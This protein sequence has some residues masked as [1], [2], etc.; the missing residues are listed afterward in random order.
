MIVQSYE[1]FCLQPTGKASFPFLDSYRADKGC[2]SLSDRFP[3]GWASDG[4]RMPIRFL[5]DGHRFL[6]EAV[7]SQWES[8]SVFLRRWTSA[9]ISIGGNIGKGRGR[10]RNI[11]IRVLSWSVSFDR[12]CLS[13]QINDAY[14]NQ[15]T[16]PIQT[17]QQCPS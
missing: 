17:S 3:N 1:I 5:P 2:R 8:S 15:L 12:Q 7:A 9:R 16:M 4:K 14:S 13:G 11:A 10:W 6:G